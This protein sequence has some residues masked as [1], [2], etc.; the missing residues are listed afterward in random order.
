MAKTTDKQTLEAAANILQAA[1]DHIERYGFDIESYGTTISSEAPRCYIGNLRAAAGIAP[2]IDYP[3]DNDGYGNPTPGDDP[4][5]GDGPELVLA[6]KALDKI[7][8]KR[9]KPARKQ[10]VKDRMGEAKHTGRFIEELGFQIR[11]KYEEKYEDD[12]LSFA[13]FEQV[14]KDYALKILR[15]ALTEIHG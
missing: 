3:V 6:L 11:D 1:H 5:E 9:L 14:Q 15:K 4:A 13:E 2:H 8:K 10:K 12:K 7:A